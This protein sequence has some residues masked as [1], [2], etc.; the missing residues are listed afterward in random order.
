MS[1]AMGM[2]QREMR[3]IPGW[4]KCSLILIRMVVH[5]CNASKHIL[6]IS[7]FTLW[8]LNFNKVDFQKISVQSIPTR[9]E[10]DFWSSLLSLTQ[11]AGDSV[12]DAYMEMAAGANFLF[13]SVYCTLLS[14]SVDAIKVRKQ[15]PK[16]VLM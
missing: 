4:Q 2:G 13:I 15:W 6:K 11:A 7:V 5:E 9:F 3:G 1:G 12:N 14:F 16:N 10:Q 8:K